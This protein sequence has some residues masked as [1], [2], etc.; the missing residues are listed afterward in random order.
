V[1]LDTTVPSIS[2]TAE[3][4]RVKTPS[5]VKGSDAEGPEP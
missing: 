2:L 4:D 1:W 5:W 3:A